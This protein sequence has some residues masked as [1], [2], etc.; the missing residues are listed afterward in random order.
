MERRQPS[1]SLNYKRQSGSPLHSAHVR[2]AFRKGSLLTG[3]IPLTALIIPSAC[4]ART[5]FAYTCSPPTQHPPQSGIMIVLI[6]SGPKC[7]PHPIDSSCRTALAGVNRPPV[8]FSSYFVIYGSLFPLILRILEYCIFAQSIEAISA[9]HSRKIPGFL[10]CGIIFPGICRQ[11][12]VTDL[13]G[14]KMELVR[15]LVRN[16]MEKKQPNGI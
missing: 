3:R 14:V 9:L 15:C 5:S 10:P 16:T 6:I 11:T 13:V 7:A 4:P 2:S 1:R 8:F 12:V